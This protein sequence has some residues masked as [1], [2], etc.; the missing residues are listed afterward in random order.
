MCSISL[1]C[2]VNLKKM[3]SLDRPYAETR[4]LAAIVRA[5]RRRPSL[6]IG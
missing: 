6:G 3:S 4:K 5:L 1:Y 2:K